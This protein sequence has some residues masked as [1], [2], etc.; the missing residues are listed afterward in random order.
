MSRQSRLYG[1]VQLTRME[2]LRHKCNMRPGL[3][4]P[5][6]TFLIVRVWLFFSFLAWQMTWSP[7]V[8]VQLQIIHLSQLIPTCNAIAKFLGFLRAQCGATSLFRVRVPF[9]FFFFCTATI[10]VGGYLFACVVQKLGTVLYC[11]VWRGAV[12]CPGSSSF[13]LCGSPAGL[14]VT[15]PSSPAQYVT[16]NTRRTYS[17]LEKRKSGSWHH[18]SWR[19]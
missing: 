13:V 10:C 12:A 7:E 8:Q 1:P 3:A 17:A 6:S 16:C 5:Q 15:S 19:E 14:T 4:Q 11:Q 9:S 2:Q 18:E